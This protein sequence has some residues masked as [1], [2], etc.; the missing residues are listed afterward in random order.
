MN[1]EEELKDFVNSEVQSEE[2]IKTNF[3]G[4]EADVD[5]VSV[6]EESQKDLAINE[7]KKYESVLDN[8]ALLEKQLEEVEAKISELC[9]DLVKERQDILNKISDNGSL[10]KAIQS[11]SLKY[12]ANAVAQDE[13]NKTLV[14]NKVQGTYVYPTKKYSFDL[15]SFVEEQNQ[16]YTENIALLNSYSTISDVSDYVKITVKKGK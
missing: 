1:L 8:N 11:E 14:Y 10:L 6:K 12:F 15:R 9:P 3:E 7:L 5:V 13:N 16:F 4:V 2:Q